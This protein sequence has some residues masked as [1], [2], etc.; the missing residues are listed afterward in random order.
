MESD[1]VFD[2]G[3]HRGE[4]SEFYLKKGF[5]VIGV[6]ANPELCAEAIE[7]FAAEIQSGQLKVINKAIAQKHGRVKFYLNSKVSVWG[8]LNPEWA[9]RNHRLGAES[10]ECEVEAITMA[11]L[12]GEF[13]MPYYMKIDIE[14]NDLLAIE[15][16]MHLRD[17]PK[18]LSI[19]SEKEGFRGLRREISIMSLLGYDQFNIVDQR[20]IVRQH[21]PNPPKE[22]R[23]VKHRFEIGSSGLFG[24]ELP[25]V[26]LTADETID[27]YRP[28]FLRYALTGD[29]PFVRSRLARILL[30]RIGFG[31]SWYD[32]H[33]RKK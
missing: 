18:Y 23:Y 33:A 25:G 10:T 2:I 7:R 22:G 8:T 6:E 3:L 4:D 31:A 17:R 29:D 9:A 12:V 27:A 11:A 14:G 28:I 13:G 24:E 21:P 16:L 32:T 26:W 30:R 5:R 1:L 19:E 15:G 20:S